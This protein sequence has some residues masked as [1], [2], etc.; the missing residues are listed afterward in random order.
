MT[1]DS[2]SEFEKFTGV[3]DLGNVDTNSAMSQLFSPTRTNIEDLDL[4]DLISP[5]PIPPASPAPKTPLNL[6]NLLEIDSRSS[7]EQLQDII[8]TAANVEAISSPKASITEVPRAQTP[9]APARAP[10]P[11]TTVKTA[12]PVSELTKSAAAVPLSSEHVSKIVNMLDNLIS[13]NQSKVQLSAI[14]KDKAAV[15]A[16]TT[17]PIKPKKQ[18]GNFLPPDSSRPLAVRPDTPKNKPKLKTSG[19]FPSSPRTPGGSPI[20]NEYSNVNSPAPSSLSSTSSDNN[21]STLETLASSLGIVRQA[22][23]PKP[24]PQITKQTDTSPQVVHTVNSTPRAKKTIIKINQG[25]AQ[26]PIV[27]GKTNSE[28]TKPTVKFLKKPVVI[29]QIPPQTHAAIRSKPAVNKTPKIVSAT[30]KTGA[31]TATNKVVVPYKSPAAK[32]EGKK[33]VLLPLEKIQNASPS[34]ISQLGLDAAIANS[35][36]RPAA[37]LPEKSTSDKRIKSETIQPTTSFTEKTEFPINITLPKQTKEKFKSEYTSSIPEMMEK[38]RAKRKSHLSS[39]SNFTQMENFIND[40]IQQN[41]DQVMEILFLKQNNKEI[42]RKY[43]QLAKLFHA[44]NAEHQKLK[45]EVEQLSMQ[46]KKME[47]ELKSI[48][49][50]IKKYMS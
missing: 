29:S 47:K 43:N 20:S 25:N 1:G 26:Q 36:K 8:N 35:N 13:S 46:N 31:P 39:M 34:V 19:S 10:T 6:E 40:F 27:I 30:I 33:Y 28:V 15:P 21:L 41:N 5:T 23:S 17:K 16:T 22:K 49:D 2:P 38:A 4:R 9:L 37:P 32:T 18:R 42:N 12:S 44:K 11:Q 50:L 24:T 45:R 3:L 14:P 48:K 7:Q